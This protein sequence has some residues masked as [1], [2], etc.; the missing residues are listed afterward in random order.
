M[1]LV[2]DDN[3]VEDVVCDVG[4][5]EAFIVAGVV[6]MDADYAV[7][8]DDATDDCIDALDDDFVDVDVVVNDDVY[9]EVVCDDVDV[10]C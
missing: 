1:V 10:D 3:V 2:G 9:A 6:V 5:F 8:V 7:D 4:N